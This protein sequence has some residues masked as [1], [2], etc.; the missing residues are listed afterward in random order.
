MMFRR[1]NRKSW[2]MACGAM[3]LSL[4]SVL[5]MSEHNENLPVLCRVPHTVRVRKS[6]THHNTRKVETNFVKVEVER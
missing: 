1:P 5:M 6:H 4:L 2:V 3:M